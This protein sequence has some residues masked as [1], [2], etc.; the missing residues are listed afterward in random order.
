MKERK[1]LMQFLLV[2]TLL[3]SLSFA[4]Y[5]QSPNVAQPKIDTICIPVADAKNKIEKAEKYDLIWEDNISLK[6]D[7]EYY[8]MSA[9]NFR[10]A[11]EIKSGEVVT[12]LREKGA[13]E[14]QTESCL[15][16]NK[17]L[18]EDV[19]VEKKKTK[20]AKVGQKIIASI[21]IVGVTAA[22][23]LSPF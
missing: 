13:A 23:L 22:L 6:K 1:N 7:K 4:G 9:E 12:A 10:D 8:R 19:A 3:L 11:Y 2:S 18:K 14:R 17:G 15:V 20:R 16:E 5:S 21:G